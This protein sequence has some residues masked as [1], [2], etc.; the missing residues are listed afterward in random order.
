MTD[1]EIIAGAPILG[2]KSVEM[3]TSP[4]LPY[5]ECGMKKKN[6]IDVDLTN[7]PCCIKKDS[8]LDKRFRE[9]E[10]AALQG[11]RYPSEWFNCLK[12]ERRPLHKINS[13][14]TFCVGPM[15]FNLLCKKYCGHFV[16]H[17][18]DTREKHFGQTGIS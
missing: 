15:D 5:V 8:L 9:R 17:F 6:L 4:G 10:K 11:K 18:I 3:A 16:Q 2:I 13:P 12:D 14:R 7:T 1:N